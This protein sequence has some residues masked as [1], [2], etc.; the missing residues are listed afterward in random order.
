M[1]GGDKAAIVMLAHETTTGQH[2][3]ATCESA[4]ELSANPT[5]V[6]VAG[7]FKFSRSS[8]LNARRSL[9]GCL[10]DKILKTTIQ[11]VSTLTIWNLRLHRS[12]TLEKRTGSVDDVQ[13]V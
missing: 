3:V 6:L 9:T 5:T 4:V 1:S 10:A 2:G 7:S 13:A 11:S 8:D 12:L